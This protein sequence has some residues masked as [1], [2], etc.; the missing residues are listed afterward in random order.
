MTAHVEA[1]PGTFDGPAPVRAAVRWPALF[2]PLFAPFGIANGYVAVTLAFLLGR[3]GLSTLAV[4][5]I[6]AA[7][8]WPQTWKVLWAP[9]VDTLGN[10]KYWYGLGAVLTG[11]TLLLMSLLPAT[12]LEVPLLT[13]LAVLSSVASTLVSMSAEIF[14]T[15]GV[16]AAMRGRASG[17]GQA[18]NLGGSGVGG[19]IGL[20]LAQHV[21]PVWV[22]GAVLAA[23]CIACWAAVLAFPPTRRDRPATGYLA[24]LAG[25]VRDV[26]DV[27]RSRIGY[28]ALVIMVLPIASAGAPWA[29]V[30]GEWHA[31]ADLVALVTGLLGGTVTAV[32]AL[33]GGYL[34]DRIDVKRAYCLFGLLAGAVATAMAWAPRSPAAFV[35]FTLVYGVFIGGGYA[36]YN[37]IVL[38][39]IGRKSAA[40]N[41]NLMAALSNV[42]I[43]AMASFDGWVHDRYGTKAM[44][45]GELALPAATI[46]AFALFVVMTRPRGGI[47]A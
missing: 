2:L 43:A 45:Y 25:V 12:A 27:A 14:M 6:I 8:I 15:T 3:A 38:E 7:S 35:G 26:W 31:G 20:A 4:T 10:P 33:A 28:L 19:G 1:A 46:A 36:A 44:L 22:S 17:W 47:A 11:G 23:I 21:S 39:A 24:H 40:T 30:A 41:F 5:T 29:A 37:A 42:P 9:I 13:T 34:C 18:G 16:P 32:G